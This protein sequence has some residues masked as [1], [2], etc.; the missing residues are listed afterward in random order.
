MQ[1]LFWRGSAEDLL[2]IEEGEEEVQG[3]GG[4]PDLPPGAVA[5]HISSSAVSVGQDEPLLEHVG[6][7]PAVKTCPSGGL[8]PS[9]VPASPAKTA[10]SPSK[11]DRMRSDA[12]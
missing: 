6:P 5:V 11:L 2:P 7:P 3:N 4:H 10:P 9:S 8:T 1:V 12:L